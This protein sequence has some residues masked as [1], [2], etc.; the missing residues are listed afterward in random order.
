[1]L[2]ELHANCFRAIRSLRFNWFQNPVV[3]L[4][5]KLKTIGLISVY[6]TKDL[7]VFEVFRKRLYRRLNKRYHGLLDFIVPAHFINQIEIMWYMVR[8]KP[9][10]E[11]TYEQ[12][13]RAITTPS[14]RKRFTPRT[15]VEKSVVSARSKPLKDNDSASNFSRDLRQLEKVNRNDK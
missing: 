9:R 15:T 12:I 6:L 3:V 4:D 11:Q 8:G 5:K 10:N 7:G 14:C 13:K 2:T 1:M